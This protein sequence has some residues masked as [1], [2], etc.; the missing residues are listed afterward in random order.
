MTVEFKRKISAC[1][2]LNQNQ[3]ELTLDVLEKYEP[4]LLVNVLLYFLIQLPDCLMTTNTYELI[5][6]ELKKG[7]QR[8][9][10]RKRKAYFT[11]E[12]APNITFLVKIIASLSISHYFTLKA[13]LGHLRK[14]TENASASTFH[15]IS[16]SVGSCILW[17]KVK[18]YETVNSKIPAKWIQ[19]LLENYEA[20]FNDNKSK[21]QRKI[22]KESVDDDKLSNST[23]ISFSFWNSFPKASSMTKP[24]S[25]EPHTKESIDSPT[26]VSSVE[27]GYVID[28]EEEYFF[29]KQ[30]QLGSW[31]CLG[32]YTWICLLNKLMLFKKKRNQ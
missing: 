3:N 18:S 6:K 16:N 9:K 11:L 20:I 2:E 14:I 8:W 21:D 17:P 29:S 25:I 15:L 19:L 22:N 30:D 12:E 5:S 24:S 10:T 7:K 31:T 13:I 23:N 1:L 32:M 27:S 26:D 28:S 4:E